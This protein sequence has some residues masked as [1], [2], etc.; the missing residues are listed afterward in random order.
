MESA[1]AAFK[2]RFKREWKQGDFL[3]WSLENYHGKPPVRMNKS[4]LWIRLRD[5]GDQ[6]KRSGLIRKE[7][8]FSAHLF[9]RTFL[10][11]LSRE[12]MK[13]VEIQRHSR[14]SNIK[15][16]I[17]HYIDQAEST[18]PYLDKILGAVA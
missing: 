4:V 1:A 13:T 9:R 10:S 2:A 15:T 18:R 14:H 12:G 17:N 11:L 16:L 6:L 5:I 8:E 3:F 7:I